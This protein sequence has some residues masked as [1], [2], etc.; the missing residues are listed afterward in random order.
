MLVYPRRNAR[1]CPWT[2]GELPV[3]TPTKFEFVINLKGAKALGHE[4]PPE[5]LAR[6]NK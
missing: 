3:Q 2:T 1:A 5:L 4:V 6:A